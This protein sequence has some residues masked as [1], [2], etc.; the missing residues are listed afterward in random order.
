LAGSLAMTLSL[1]LNFYKSKKPLSRRQGNED[2]SEQ[3]FWSGV[4]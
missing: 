1:P 3:L 4:D 2:G